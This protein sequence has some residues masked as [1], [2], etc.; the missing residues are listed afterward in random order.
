M[1]KEEIY[2]KHGDCPEKCQIVL[3]DDGGC[4]DPECCG[5]T[6]YHIEIEC[7]KHGTINIY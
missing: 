4:N 3:G 7:P 1:S 5:G 2:A 6:N